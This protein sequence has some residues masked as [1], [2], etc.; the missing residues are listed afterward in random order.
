[1]NRSIPFYKV[2]QKKLDKVT[3]I[4][5]ENLTGARVIRAFSKQDDEKKRFF[6]ATMDFKKA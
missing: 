5:R 3:R 4:T 1:M 6:E 2:N